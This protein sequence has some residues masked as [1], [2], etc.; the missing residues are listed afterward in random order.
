MERFVKLSD[1][2]ATFRKKKVR[3]EVGHFAVSGLEF[4]IGIKENR[5][6]CLGKIFNE[7]IKKLEIKQN[8]AEHHSL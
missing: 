2:S 3:S 5:T 1:I 6:V 4:L 7:N 8:L